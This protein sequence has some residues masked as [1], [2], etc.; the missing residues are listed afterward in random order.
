MYVCMYNLCLYVCV[1][2]CACL[3]AHAAHYSITFAARLDLRPLSA[4][5][6]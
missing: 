2:S 5:Q 1:W 3:Q 4:H 6:V